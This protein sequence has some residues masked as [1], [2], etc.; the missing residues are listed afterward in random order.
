MRSVKP[1]I[2]PLK[3]STPLPKRTMRIYMTVQGMTQQAQSSPHKHPVF[4]GEGFATEAAL[5]ETEPFVEPGIFCSDV[6]V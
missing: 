4:I 1:S 5:E 3:T 2:I 6:L